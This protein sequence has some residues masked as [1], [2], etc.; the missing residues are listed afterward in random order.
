MEAQ[1][2]KG[3]K[4]IVP[5]AAQGIRFAIA[6]RL[7][8]EGAAV[9]LADIDSVRAA[10]AAAQIGMVEGA[11]TS[12]K[13]GIVNPASTAELLDETQRMIINIASIVGIRGSRDSACYLTAKGASSI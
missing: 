7:V 6:Q 8:R 11:A 9:I 12:L 5:G 4:A 13:A 10:E 1:R 2:L 3:K